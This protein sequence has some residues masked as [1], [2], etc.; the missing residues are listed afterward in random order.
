MVNKKYDNCS[1]TSK[2][3][4]E[5]KK[6]LDDISHD[7]DMCTNEILEAYWKKFPKSRVVQCWYDIPCESGDSCVKTSL[8]RD[9]FCGSNITCMNEVCILAPSPCLIP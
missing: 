7:I 3:F 6:C 5:N 4:E 9:P 2:S 1:A 8:A